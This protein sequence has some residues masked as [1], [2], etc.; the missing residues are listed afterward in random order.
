[1]SLDTL[2][3]KAQMHRYLYQNMDGFQQI[4]FCALAAV[5]LAVAMTGALKILVG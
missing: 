4:A 1:M 3:E 5:F 2:P